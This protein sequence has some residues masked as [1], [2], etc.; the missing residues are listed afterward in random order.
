MDKIMA[1]SAPGS[2][3]SMRSAAT[4][5]AKTTTAIPTD[6]QLTWLSWGQW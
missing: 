2:R 5:T 1:A 3:W 6:H 4:I